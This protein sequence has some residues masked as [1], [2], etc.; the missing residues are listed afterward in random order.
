[1]PSSTHRILS[2]RGK[3]QTR[4]S[5]APT[6]TASTTNIRNTLPTGRGRDSVIRGILLLLQKQNDEKTEEIRTV[7]SAVS[8]FGVAAPSTRRSES[9]ND[10]ILIDTKPQ[11]QH[12]QNRRFLLTPSN[13]SPKVLQEGHH[14]PHRRHHDHNNENTSNFVRWTLSDAA[15]ATT[16]T[17]TSNDSSCT[18]AGTTTTNATSSSDLRVV[19]E[20]FPIGYGR[21]ANSPVQVVATKLA[22]AT[23]ITTTT[24]SASGISAA[25]TTTCRDLNDDDD[26]DDEDGTRSME[27]SRPT[28]AQ[29]TTTTTV[30]DL[31][32]V[33]DIHQRRQRDHFG[34]HSH[35]HSVCDSSS[36]VLPPTL[37]SSTSLSKLTR[38]LRRRHQTY[39]D[40]CSAVT[41][42]LPRSFMTL[43]DLA[44]C[45]T[46]QERRTTTR[47]ITTTSL[48]ARSPRSPN[49]TDFLV[50][51]G[52]PNK[53][54]TTNTIEINLTEEQKAL[55][56]KKFEEMKDYQEENNGSSYPPLGTSLRYWAS[57]QRTTFK[58]KRMYTYRIELLNSINFQWSKTGSGP[59]LDWDRMYD[60]LVEYKER[61]G[62]TKVPQ[63]YPKDQQ[64]GKWCYTQKT[65][66][67]KGTLDP[68]R[69]AKLDGIGFVF[70]EIVSLE[71]RWEEKYKRLVEY[72]KKHNST[73]VPIEFEDDPEL[74]K[75]VGEQRRLY[76]Y[77]DSRMTPERIERLEAIGF[78]WNAQEALWQEMYSRLVDYKHEKGDANV[79]QGYDEDPKLGIWV[80][81]QRT[82]YKKGKMSSNRIEKL[83]AIGF[84]WRI[85]KSKEEKDELQD[86]LW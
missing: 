71:E 63:N 76:S 29:V 86:G 34:Y 2:L 48:Y 23:S 60:R 79:P 69:K 51:D 49:D 24:T 68:E 67:H 38:P 14:R 57:W 81:N 28:P 65:N 84:R 53:D 25:A 37:T 30:L 42:K 15:A 12:R 41:L 59:N 82:A 64:L 74:G 73:I 6:N 31:P 4:D 50:D 9:T 22:N 35:R 44:I 20:S 62:D 78:V 36:F 3:K 8:S 5:D 46:I 70:D 11:K 26:Y 58:K 33:V 52:S 39:L 27:A 55:W 77:N 83:E 80:S 16:T 43:Q 47:L 19:H 56:Q 54:G 21:S 32:I 17:T 72:W 75:W 13:I 10:G 45:R 66:Y 7:S 61:C 18:S 40:T 85:N 1:M